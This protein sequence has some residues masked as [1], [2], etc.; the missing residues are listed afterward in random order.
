MGIQGFWSFVVKNYYEA[1]TSLG[2]LS[3]FDGQ[4]WAIDTSIYMYK[5]ALKEDFIEAFLQQAE[6]L[7]TWGIT[8][9]YIFDG[10]RH[11]DKLHEHVRRREQARRYLENAAVRTDLLA[12]L[13]ADTN[14]ST[15]EARELLTT[16]VTD[17]VQRSLSNTAVAEMTGCDDVEIELDLNAVITK[18]RERHAR[19]DSRVIKVPDE[20]YE[21]LMQVFNARNIAYCIAVGDAEKLGAHLCRTGRV[22]ALVTDDGDALA[23]GATVVIRNLF[24][25]GKSGMEAVSLYALLALMQITQEQLVDLAIICGCDYTESRGLPGLG[26]VKALKV[27]QKYGSLQAFLD[28]PEFLSKYETFDL[29]KF[30][31]EQARAIFLDSSNQLGFSS[32]SF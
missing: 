14:L 10:Q 31:Y 18:I 32:L 23:F 19:Q 5:F 25:P 17:E 26:P 11:P 15:E 8:P 29:N 13:T 9:V 3:A 24:R 20:N 30:Q 1:F 12:K 28:S 6:E 4:T 16:H 27:M 22:Q 21:Q 7:K 2:D